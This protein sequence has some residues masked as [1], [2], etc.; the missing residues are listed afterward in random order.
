MESLVSVLFVLIAIAGI[1]ALELRQAKSSIIA[2]G[3][4]LALFAVAMFAMGAVE[5]GIGA[6]V[7]A[8]ALLATLKWAVA[9]TGATD[10]VP[11]FAEGKGMVFSA[12]GL[13][14]FVVVVL[15]LVKQHLPIDAMAQLDGEGGGHVGL[16]REGLVIVTALA[17]VWAML[18]KTGRRD[19]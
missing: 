5:V 4:A 17:A 8:V 15:V 16:L 19:Q 3:I 14:A 13:A 9:Q 6:L 11:A 1:A 18:R 10:S 12:L 2:V 7:A